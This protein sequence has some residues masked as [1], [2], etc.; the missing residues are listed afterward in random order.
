MQFLATAL[1]AAPARSGMPPL[2][3]AAVLAAALTH[4]I[5]NALA[6]AVRDK[7]TMAALMGAGSAVIAAP[8]VL[9]AP[10]PAAGAWPYIIASAILHVGYNGL[11]LLS[12][13][14]G[15]F[16]QVYPVARGTSPWLVGIAGAVF[17]GDRLS[18]LGW[19]GVAVV[20]AGL[21][22]L[23]F[24]GGYRPTRTDVPAL[25]AALGTGVAIASYTVVDGLGVRLSGGALSY[26]AWLFLLEGV[27]TLL[28]ALPLRR[29]GGWN[30]A[31]AW[32]TGLA[33]AALSILAYG[34]VLWAQTQGALA[35]V[36]ALRETSV[37]A[38][39]IIGAMFFRE[40][41]GRG[42][43]AGAV[44]VATGIALINLG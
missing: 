39:A 43:I 8:L 41:F 22:S 2:A 25:A 17:A 13:R 30:V 35:A 10:M 5:W 19:T 42:R 7:L 28:A 29:H 12:F 36:A 26:A 37:I 23:V 9:L 44:I 3:V 24:A 18:P 1:S 21:M 32:R 6:H 40:S 27:L 20:S 34:L 16:S 11:L 33:C 38:G 4:A 15:E 14:L 31:G